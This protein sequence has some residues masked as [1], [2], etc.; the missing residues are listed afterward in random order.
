MAGPANIL[1]DN[2]YQSGGLSPSQQAGL[3]RQNKNFAR[4]NQVNSLG[5]AILP[6]H[7][8]DYNREEEEEEELDEEGGKKTSSGSDYDRPENLHSYNKKGEM[9]SGIGND[10]ESRQGAKSYS[11]NDAPSMSGTQASGGVASAGQFRQEKATARKGRDKEQA[12]HRM[13]QAMYEMAENF[14]EKKMGKLGGLGQIKDFV[15]GDFVEMFKNQMIKNGV[16]WVWEAVLPSWGLAIFVLDWF[17]YYDSKHGKLLPQWQKMAIA[18]VTI[19]YLTLILAI[20]AAIFQLV[21][22]PLMG[23][24]KLVG[25]V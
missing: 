6:A 4:N 8:T 16:K 20:A 11:L 5:S 18:F 15:N 23:L 3:M 2:E 1:S 22:G 14:A 24:I 7:N 25:A 12:K 13:M 19:I 21:I 9:V 10:A 17:W